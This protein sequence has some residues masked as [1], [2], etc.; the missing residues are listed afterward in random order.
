[1]RGYIE[2]CLKRQLKQYV[3]KR[4]QAIANIPAAVEEILETAVISDIN[5]TTTPRK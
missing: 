4:K 3:D 2:D 5:E 1:M